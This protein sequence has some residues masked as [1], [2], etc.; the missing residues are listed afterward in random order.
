M[1]III[2][3]NLFIIIYCVGKLENTIQVAGMLAISQILFNVHIYLYIDYLSQLNL[4]IG[5]TH[6]SFLIMTNSNFKS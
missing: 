1:K 6:F 2:Y 3:S 4:N 5:V